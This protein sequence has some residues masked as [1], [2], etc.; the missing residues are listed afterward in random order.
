MITNFE[1]ITYELT[2][3]EQETLLP[4]LV[5]GFKLKIG[6]ANAIT[7]KEIIARL[8]K[9]GYNINGARTRKLV[10]HIRINGLVP[11]L[12]ATSSGYYITND[13]EELKT[14]LTSLKER[15]SAI[16][17]VLHALE[18]DYFEFY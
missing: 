10:H 12:M 8:T 17:S 4:L 14:Y 9:G 13:K 16:G 2:Q 6:K 15:I 11:R 5:K 7:S 18:K 3:Y 1:N